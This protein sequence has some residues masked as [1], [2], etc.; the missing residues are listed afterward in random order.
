[1][2]EATRLCRPFMISSM[3][4]SQSHCASAVSVLV[5][6]RKGRA[7]HEVDVEDVDVVRA[8]LLERRFEGDDHRL[9]AVPDILHL[10]RD[11]LPVRAAH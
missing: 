8:Q 4:V 1:M 2:P 3:D 5:N 11:G 10:L 7:T 6:C 9:D